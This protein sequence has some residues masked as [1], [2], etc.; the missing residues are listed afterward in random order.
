MAVLPQNYP[1]A[2]QILLKLDGEVQQGLSRKPLNLWADL[3]YPSK[4][5]EFGYYTEYK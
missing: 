5:K 4:K 1:T 3:L 2:R